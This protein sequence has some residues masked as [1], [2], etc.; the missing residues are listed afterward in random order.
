MV[1]DHFHDKWRDNPLVPNP[2]FPKRDPLNQSNWMPPK[3][4]VTKKEFDKLK[5]EV[6][7]MKKLLIRAKLYDEANNE[8]SCEVEEKME[9]LRKVAQLVGVDLDDVFKKQP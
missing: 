8:P 4:E 3:T 7:E 9:F 5:A 6:E 2:F 1:G